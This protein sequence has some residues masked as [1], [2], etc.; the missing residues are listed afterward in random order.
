MKKVLVTGASGFVGSHLITRLAQN[1]FA[2]RAVYRNLPKDTVNSTDTLPSTGKGFVEAFLLPDVSKK[3]DLDRAVEGVNTIVH[4]AGL[5]HSKPT[6]KRLEESEHTRINTEHTKYWAEAAIKADVKRF[7]YLST[8]K[9]L[10]EF[11]P[12]GKTFNELSV[13]F[14]RD[15]YSQ[16]KLKAEEAIK[17]FC[18]NKN[19]EYVILRPPLIYGPGAK[20]NM[21]NLVNYVN[22]RLILFVP[23][24]KNKRSIISISNLSDAITSCIEHPAA[25]NETFMV[26]DG[27]DV[28]TGELIQLIS[29]ALGGIKVAVP[30]SKFALFFVGFVGDLYYHVTGKRNNVDSE[31]IFKLQSSLRIDVSKIQG[32]LGWVAS[33][34]LKSGVSSMVTKDK[35]DHCSS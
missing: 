28:S 34:T 24:V 5:A 26:S 32:Q 3:A 2:T 25:A 18:K 1:G 20:G 12:E 27:R 4:L 29:E 21:S 11:T 16:S 14:P 13:P 33:E 15:S 23:T 22:K 8:I 31:A 19:T 30:V 6:I 9:V 10:G 17:K 35:L 7:I